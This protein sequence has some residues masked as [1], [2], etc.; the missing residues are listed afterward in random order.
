[1][2]TQLE[3]SGGEAVVKILIQ[4]NIKYVFGMAGFQHLPMYDALHRHKSEI[5]HVLIRDEK[6]GAFMADAYARVS[7]EIAACDATVGPGVTNLLSGLAEAYYA[8][9]PMLVITS[10]VNSQYAGRGLNQECDQLTA[11][12]PLCKKS[13]FINSIQRIPEI[14]N[15]AILSIK[16]GT[17]GP[18]YVD[19]PEDVFHGK[20]NFDEKI[21]ESTT[22]NKPI[23]SRPSKK[24]LEEA[25]DVLVDAKRPIII[26]G[27]GIHLSEAWEPLRKFAEKLSIPIATTMTGKGSIEEDHPLSLGLVGRFSKCAN[28]F[29][30]QA[31]VILV[32]GCRLGEMSTNRWTLIPDESKLIQ[33]DSDPY[34]IGKNYSVEVGLCGDAKLA[35]E[36]FL[37][38]SKD[39]EPKK[40]IDLENEIKAKIKDWENGN[41]SKWINNDVGITIPMI[42]NELRDNLPQDSILI[43]DGGLAAHWSSVYYKILKAGRTYVANRGQAAIGY[44]LPAGIGAKLACP[45]KTVVSL[46]GDGGFGMAIMELETAVRMKI[47]PLFVIIDNEVLGYIKGLQ[48]Q[49]FEGRY[50][51]SEMKFVNYANIAKEIGCKSFQ[52]T[53]KDQLKTEVKKAVDFIKQKG[54]DRPYVL[55]IKVSSN[56]DTLF[57]GI[58]TRTAVYKK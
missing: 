39:M 34:Q 26:A 28:K 35:L 48:Y 16:A 55:D 20:N 42:L 56:P 13:Y 14:L 36:D 40:N 25:F 21:F 33:I 7:N 11:F 15:R 9:I 52:I 37:E 5:T 10:D 12:R 17:P 19:I 32:V 51:S 3:L 18:V 58:D 30:K 22:F 27:G 57:P 49:I 45:E 24:D 29:I 2:S 50:I 6:D 4:N 31:D 8:S 54:A 38:I 53:D 44:G 1:M 47:A 41:L 46:A 43:A 23:F